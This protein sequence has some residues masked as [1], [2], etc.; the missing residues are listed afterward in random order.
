MGK[1]RYAVEFKVRLCLLG[2][3]GMMGAHR[4]APSL[5]DVPSL[6]GHVTRALARSREQLIG[7]QHALHSTSSPR[8][9]GTR[10]C[11]EQTDMRMAVNAVPCSLSCTCL[12]CPLTFCAAAPQGDR[13]GGRGARRRPRLGIFDDIEEDVPRK[14]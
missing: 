2:F 9:A 10:R 12:P 3:S 5:A 8:N 4:D 13:A 1:R 11:V 14:M 7:E 6:T